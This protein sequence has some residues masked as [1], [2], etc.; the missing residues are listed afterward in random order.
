MGITCSR[1]LL[2]VLL[3]ALIDQTFKVATSSSSGVPALLFGQNCQH[4]AD[5]KGGP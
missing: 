1:T 5:T 3:C 4:Q 2:R